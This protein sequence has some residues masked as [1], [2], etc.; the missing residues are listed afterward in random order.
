MQNER[1]DL[2]AL[3]IMISLSSSSL[4][5]S[6]IRKKYHFNHF[7]CGSVRL[8][9]H[10]LRVGLFDHYAHHRSAQFTG[11]K[12]S[13]RNRIIWWIWGEKQDDQRAV[14][15]HEPGNQQQ[16]GFTTWIPVCDLWRYR[17]EWDQDEGWCKQAAQMW[18]LI[19]I[20][21][22]TSSLLFC[23][24]GSQWKLNF[25]L[26]FQDSS[27]NLALLILFYFF[28]IYFFLQKSWFIQKV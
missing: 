9:R 17:Q 3:I 4:F 25:L 14:Y 6:Y 19:F 15:Q 22:K 8:C 5:I 13:L 28:Y 21:F 27:L 16:H 18:A 11:L 2:K 7:Q 26:C 20:L 1:L 10:G 24:V 12:S 23:Y